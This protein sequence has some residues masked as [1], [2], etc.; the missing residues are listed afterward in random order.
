[1][2]IFCFYFFSLMN[3]TYSIKLLK[4]RT[5]N[6]DMMMM[7]IVVSWLVGWLIGWVTHN[8]HTHTPYYTSVITYRFKFSFWLLSCCCCCSLVLC[9]F[10]WCE[11]E[12]GWL[13]V[14]KKN[15]LIWWHIHTHMSLVIKEKK[16]L[17]VQWSVI[18]R[19]GT[20]NQKIKNKKKSSQDKQTKN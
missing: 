15:S 7:T 5:N 20:H 12:N 19:S 13:V 17:R 11:C 1:M 9:L 3:S 2:R 10:V 6:H 16:N 4:K 18:F 14:I 8:V